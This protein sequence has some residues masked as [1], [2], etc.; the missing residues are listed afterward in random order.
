MTIQEGEELLEHVSSV[1]RGRG[2][3]QEA[4]DWWCRRRVY[5]ADWV[6]EA[7]PGPLQSRHGTQV[8]PLEVDQE[9]LADCWLRSPDPLAFS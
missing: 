2:F 9:V 3:W 6:V 4:A 7:S 1:G 8:E 5:I